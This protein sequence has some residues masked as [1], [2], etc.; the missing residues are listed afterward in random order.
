MKNFRIIALEKLSDSSNYQLIEEGIYND[1]HDSGG[2]S[3]YRMAMAVDSEADDTG[4]YPLEDIL[5]QFLVHVEEFIESPDED[6]RMFM[7]GGELDDLQ[8]FKSIIGR[9]AFNEEFTDENGQTRV[10]LK[11]E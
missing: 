3:T 5:D 9:R 6:V 11:I 8:N 1:L 4:Q 7:F 2:F 10:R